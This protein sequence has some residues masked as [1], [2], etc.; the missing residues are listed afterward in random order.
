[1][2]RT[3]HPLYEALRDI[4]EFKLKLAEYFKDKD[5]F[6]IKS[7][8][9]L[10]NLL[11]CGISLKCGEVEASELVKLLDESDFPIK[12]LNDLVTKLSKKCPI[13]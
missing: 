11:P 10:A 4:E 6:P 9:E 7:R 1:M 3:N 2:I 5:V 13:E 8:V 12:D